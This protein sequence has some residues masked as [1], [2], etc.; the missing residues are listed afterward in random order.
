MSD[1]YACAG[2]RRTKKDL[3]KKAKQRVYKK[4]GAHRSDKD[5]V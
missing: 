5:R 1:D 4:G 3:R 2:K